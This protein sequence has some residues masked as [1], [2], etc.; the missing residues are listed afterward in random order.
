MLRDLAWTL[1]VALGLGIIF[2]ILTSEARSHEWYPLA[3]CSDQ[4]CWPADGAREPEPH[5]TPTGWQLSDGTIIPYH[6]ARPSPDGQF[7]VCRYGG[8]RTGS[9]IRTPDGKPCLWVPQSGS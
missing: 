3:C 2:A 7:H 9:L 8:N 4:D 5:A 1:A 6:E